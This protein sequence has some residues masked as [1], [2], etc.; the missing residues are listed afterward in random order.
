MHLSTN[1]L[2]TIFFTNTDI[3]TFP[4]INKRIPISS[5]F[6]YSN[7]LQAEKLLDKYFVANKKAI[8]KEYKPC[9]AVVLQTDDKKTA[10]KL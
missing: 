5:I 4:L 7:H 9:M 3:L 6:V 10:K 2:S 1:S 8:K